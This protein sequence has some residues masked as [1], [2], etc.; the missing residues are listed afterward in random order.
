VEKKMTE[1]EKMVLA[2]F[3]FGIISEFVT[4]VKLG[5]GE[6]QR[7]LAEKAG[8]SYQIPMSKRTSIKRSTI[9]QWIYDY[10]KAGHQ[11]EGLKPKSRSDKGTYKSK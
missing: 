1:E 9:L 11:I 6:K 8:R 5:Y 7:L 10:K 4:G 3:R 2:T